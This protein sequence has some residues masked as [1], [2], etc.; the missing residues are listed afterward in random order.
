VRRPPLWQ[1]AWLHRQLQHGLLA[2]C[3]SPN[4]GDPKFASE[5]CFCGLCPDNTT[6]CTTNNDCGGGQC[7]GAPANCDP[8]PLPFNDDGTMNT[9]FKP[10]FSPEQCR[11]A[12]VVGTATRPNSCR[13]GQCAWNADLAVGTCPSVLTGQMVGCYPTGKG[14]KVIAPGGAHKIGSVWVVDT[15]TAFCTRPQSAPV[16][17]QLGLPGLT[18][19]RKSFRIIP[20]YPTK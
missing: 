7:S 13:N 15:G 6:T 8:Q 17:G 12:G 4:C 20:E 9:D 2:E 3:A 1:P 16:N 10:G 11:T 19:Q 5:K 18:F 14:A